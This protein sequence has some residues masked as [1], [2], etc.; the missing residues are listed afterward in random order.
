LG[1]SLADC[2][3]EMTAEQM[4]SPTVGRWVYL[5]ADCLEVLKAEM[6]A[7]ILVDKKAPMLVGSKAAY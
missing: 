2:W 7:S 1:A 5:M 6:L 3:G 4:V